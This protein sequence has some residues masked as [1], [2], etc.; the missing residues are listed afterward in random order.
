MPFIKDGQPVPHAFL[1]CGCY[2]EERIIHHPNP[3]DFDFPM[4]GTFRGFSFEYCG[5]SDP[6]RVPASNMSELEDRISNLEEISAMPGRIPRKYY[7]QFQQ[8]QG[9]VANLRNRV[10]E[11]SAKKRRPAKSAYKGLVVESE[12]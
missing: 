2:E 7:D 8:I 6:R 9:E 10:T 1:W 5:M 3:E 4:S 11:L 12:S